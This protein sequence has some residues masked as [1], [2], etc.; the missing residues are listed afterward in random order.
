MQ[1]LC[2]GD[3]HSGLYQF[4]PNFPDSTKVAEMEVKKDDD[5]SLPEAAMSFHPTTHKS[6]TTLE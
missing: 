4:S 6:V 5:E 3:A 2:D 1:D